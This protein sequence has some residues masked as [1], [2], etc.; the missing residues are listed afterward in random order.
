MKK[1]QAGSVSKDS[2]RPEDLI[3]AL[4]DELESLDLRYAQ[5]IVADYIA[6]GWP[7]DYNRYEATLLLGLIINDPLPDEL[8]ELAGHLLEDLS[9]ALDARAPE[10][11]YFGAAAGHGSDFGFWRFE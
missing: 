5:E 11:Y 8:M 10:G 6:S 9:S 2:M 7:G 4:M 3:P 1:A